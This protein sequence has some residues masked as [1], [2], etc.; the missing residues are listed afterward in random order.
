MSAEINNTFCV[1]PFVQSVVRTDG[2][3]SPCCNM[4]GISNINNIDIEQYWASEEIKQL[5][6]DLL[7]ARSVDRCS[8]C[9]DQEKTIGKSMRTESLK[10]YK[11]FDQRYYKKLVEHHG[12]LNK[13]F[14]S[15]IEMHLGNLCNLKCLT[16]RPEDS[17]AFL[18]ENHLLKISTHRQSDYQFDDEVICHNFELILKN[19][20]D[21][22]DLRGGES[23]L[24]PVIKDLLNKLPA[25]HDISVLRI[26][27]NGTILD[28]SWKNIFKKFSKVEIMLSIDAYGSGNEYI[29]YPSKWDTLEKNIDYFLSIPN[30]KIYLNCTVS[31]L[32][33]L[34][35]DQLVEWANKKNIFFHYS[36]VK[37]PTYYQY[38]NLPKE[39]FDQMKEKLSHYPE[40]SGLTRLGADD[41]YWVEF[42]NMINVRDQHRK[43]SIFNMLPQLKQYWK[44]T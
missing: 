41:K 18:T 8:A 14:P 11:F 36:T 25:T 5:Q 22:L 31:N 13:S 3:I 6:N 4:S 1:F 30:G 21:V 2:F 35:L 43:N 40:V 9:Y 39:L 38:T 44:T 23:M 37:T 24:M 17:S 19:K 15:R 28:D 7:E 10:D 33:F 34:L 29:R 20:V 12:Y 42:C 32:N 27:T 16:C 26:Q